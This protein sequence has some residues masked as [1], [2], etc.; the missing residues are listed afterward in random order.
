MRRKYKY[1]V[2]D[3]EM[4]KKDF[5]NELKLCCQKVKDTI[6][7]GYIGVDLCEL[8]KKEFNSDMRDIE[9]GIRV[10]RDGK[11]FRRKAVI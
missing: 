10:I 9:N 4:S 7:C 5:E 8:D 2:N 6:V 1:F 11:M 3:N